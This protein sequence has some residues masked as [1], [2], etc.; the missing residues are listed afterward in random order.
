MKGKKTHLQALALISLSWQLDSFL[1]S[2]L[3][4]ASISSFQ[5]SWLKVPHLECHYSIFKWYLNFPPVRVLFIHLLWPHHFLLLL[6]HH[7]GHTGRICV[8]INICWSICATL[9][10]A[11]YSLLSDCP[12]FFQAHNT[13]SVCI[14]VSVFYLR[15]RWCMN[16]LHSISALTLPFPSCCEGLN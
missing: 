7:R 15:D 1:D 10:A 8:G 14:P 2:Q 5:D 16:Y 9:Q 4:T 6:T 3:L 13:G 12:L 11:T